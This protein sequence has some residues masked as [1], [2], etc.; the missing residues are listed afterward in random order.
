MGASRILWCKGPKTLMFGY[1]YNTGRG[2]FTF[3]QKSHIS[4]SLPMFNVCFVMW[5]ID[6]PLTLYIHQLTYLSN[7][8]H[9]VGLVLWNLFYCIIYRNCHWLIEVWVL[10]CIWGINGVINYLSANISLL[11][12]TNGRWITSES[13][14]YHSSIFLSQIIVHNIKDVLSL[15]LNLVLF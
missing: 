4:F 2:H 8:H 15:H 6:I 10:V 7:S 11:S 12:H 9:V 3:I 5:K 14:R 1:Y 13:Q